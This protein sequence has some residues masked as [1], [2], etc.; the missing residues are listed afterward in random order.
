MT[1]RRLGV[2][3]VEA[4]LGAG[5]MG[6]VYRARD[7][8]LG[9]DV[10][11]KILPRA[12]TSDPE[13]LARFQRE[14]RVLAALNHPNIG[15]IYGLEDN[16]GSPALV[17]EFIDGETLADRIARG[18][19]SPKDALSIARQLT[20]ALAAAHDKGIV[21]RDLKPRNI[22]LTRDGTVKVLDFGLAKASI[23]SDAAPGHSDAPTMSIGGTLQGVVLGTAAYMSPE[24]ARGHAIDHR[25][26]IWAF[27]C[28]LYEMLTSRAAFPG[29]TIPD[30]IAAV[31]ERDPN[32][33]ALPPV[34]PRP[35]RRLLERCLTKNR[36]ER[37]G[38]INGARPLLESRSSRAGVPRL[39]VTFAV[40]AAI[41]V[42]VATMWVNF[43]GAPASRPI[44][45]QITHFATPV[46]DPALSPDGRM[47]A[48]VVQEPRGV[49]S[50]IYV[51]SASG[52]RPQP[53][54]RT[55]GRKAWPA[56]SRDGSQI[57]FTLT[58][59]EWKWDT[60]VVPLVGGEAP[61][62]L[63]PNA[64]QLQWL[65]DG[66][67]LFSEFK[68]GIQVAVVAA[69]AG[70]SEARDIYVPPPAGMAHVSDLSPDGRLVAIGQMSPLS[71][72]VMP[73]HGRGEQQSIGT[74]EIPCSM[75]VRWS[76]DGRWLYFASGQAPDFQLFRQPAGGGR[77]EQLTF[78][79]G[80]AGIG[81]V[82]WFALTGDGRSVVYPSGE[83]HETVWLQRSGENDRQ[84][85]FEGDAR[86]PGI[87]GRHLVYLS[88]PRFSPAQIWTRSLDGSSAVQVAGDFRA[89]SLAPSRDGTFIAFAG[90]DGHKKVHL[91]LASIDSSWAPRE[92]DVG[93]HEVGDVFVA[94]DNETLFYVAREGATT[95][96]WRVDAN[97]KNRRPITEREPSLRLSSVSP[98]G[99]WISVTRGARTP[100]EEWI[101]QADGGGSRML[102]P[103]WR[104]RWMPGNRSFLLI[105]SGMVSTAWLVPNPTG[106]DLPTQMPANPTAENLT[107]LG[108][109]KVLT[110]DF[111]VEP[112]P[113]PDSSSI[114]YSKVENRSNLFQLALPK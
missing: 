70:R 71:C 31:L 79:R 16:E 112:L 89:V 52:G 5:G 51:Q 4:Q 92:I 65:D 108:G 73:F 45:V 81:V 53:L 69:R 104:F 101:Y 97:G 21:H 49:D 34:T 77:P 37:L 8:K 95:Q 13:R 2:Y 11:L 114:V 42:G 78:D 48:Y 6:E 12:F 62:L 36:A 26:D 85:T 23:D 57:A 39:A 64:H 76:R 109:R 83:A 105:N 107:R 60:W 66:R 27:G 61:R 24:Q 35:V 17:L 33:A 75:F 67:V 113:G 44:P 15:A 14:A 40:V 25:T 58:G 7:T 98:D 1:G 3:Q 22:A 29:E 91:W 102:F 68:K 87:S 47:L 43:G 96:I 54:T 72:F 28:V 10:A 46:R 50:Q 9:R 56:F 80:L 88:G 90:P 100:R 82:T 38:D 94:P 20:E 30:T 99:R 84:L 19:I 32:W 59:E 18:P 63:M 106:A 74:P 86:N 93:D 41:I 110:A 55:P 111:F 103:N